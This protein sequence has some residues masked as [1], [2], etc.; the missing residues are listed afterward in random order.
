MREHERASEMC[1]ER[2]CERESQ[3]V[4]A[5]G[6]R[7]VLMSV[8][9]VGE[10]K[11]T[12]AARFIGGRMSRFVAGARPRRETNNL[13]PDYSK[14]ENDDAKP[15]YRSVIE[16]SSFSP[17]VKAKVA[18]WHQRSMDML[19]AMQLATVSLAHNAAIERLMALGYA[20][21]RATT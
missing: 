20:Q 19:D 7:D 5:S 14:S 4:L 8:A 12:D 13:F 17:E 9:R 1:C 2:G 3:R 15:T 18:A 21:S 10:H 16:E 6:R 11:R